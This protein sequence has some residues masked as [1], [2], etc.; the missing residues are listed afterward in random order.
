L[1]PHAGRVVVA[2]NKADEL[3]DE[4]SHYAFH[5]LGLGDP[6]PVSA[7]IGKGS[8]DLLDCIVALLP[9]VSDRGETDTVG[10]A[11]VGRPNVGKSSL[12][13]R[14]LGQD[15]SLVAPEAGTTRDAVDS[16]LRFHGRTLNFIDTAGLRKRSK[17]EDEIEFY[18]TLRTER[19]IEQADVCVLV[20]DASRGMQ[21]QDLKIAQTAWQRGTGLVI[22]VSKW[23]LVDKETATALRG[24]REV[25]DRAPFLRAVPFLYVSSSTGQRTRSVLDAIVAVSEQRERRVATA[26]VNRV[27]TKLVARSQPPQHRGQEVKLYY[28]S[29]I[30]I[31]PPTFAVVANHPDA[32]PESYRRFLENGFRDEWGFSGAP[33]RIKLRRKRRRP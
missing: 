13:N 27:L 9:Q 29:Q 24:E 18:S 25:A 21:T 3:P 15:R 26:E 6:H 22:A 12:V 20:V 1:R 23:D 5:Q 10:V 19:A 14:L 4:T 17:V 32:I 28:A 33:L 7:A 16:P 8:G 2:A 11:V 31:R 30:G